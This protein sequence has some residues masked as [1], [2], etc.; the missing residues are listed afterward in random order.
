MLKIGATI[1][2]VYAREVPLPITVV[3]DDIT[4]TGLKR[5]GAVRALCTPE[6]PRGRTKFAGIYCAATWRGSAFTTEALPELISS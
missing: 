4:L 6:R 3:T 5:N 1:A 2:R